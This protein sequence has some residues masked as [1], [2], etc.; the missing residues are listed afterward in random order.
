MLTPSTRLKLQAILRRI[1][2]NESVSLSERIY[3]QKFADHDATVA[4][5][6]R[7]AR[8]MQRPVTSNGVDQLLTGLDLGDVDPDTSPR[9][10]PDDDLGDWFSGAPDWLRRS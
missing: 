2:H 3:V 10:G 9:Q 5:W 4:S 1:G 8:R 7:R 6:L